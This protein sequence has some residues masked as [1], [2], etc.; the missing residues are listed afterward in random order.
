MINYETLKELMKLAGISELEQRL[1]I[2]IVQESICHSKDRW[3]EVANNMCKTRSE[4]K[5]CDIAHSVQL[6]QRIHVE[7]DS[8]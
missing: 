6:I 2:S 5:L 3:R 4:A 7:R 1:I 8:G